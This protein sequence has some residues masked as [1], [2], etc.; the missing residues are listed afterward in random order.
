MLTR[1]LPADAFRAKDSSL[2]PVA[3]RGIPDPEAREAGFS[4]GL[5]KG[6]FSA[7][8]WPVASNL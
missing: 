5:V 1:P 8:P 4:P 7:L 2:A 6:A 3:K